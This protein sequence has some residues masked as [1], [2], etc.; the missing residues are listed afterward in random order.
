MTGCERAAIPG[1]TSHFLLMLGSQLSPGFWISE[2]WPAVAVWIRLGAA[3]EPLLQ[4]SASPGDSLREEGA[5]LSGLGCPSCLVQ[6]GCMHEDEACQGAHVG[7]WPVDVDV[8]KQ[9][10]LGH[11]VGL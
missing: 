3:G 11:G 10:G 8:C 5:W 7:F 4:A 1:Q 2:V 9:R 6:P